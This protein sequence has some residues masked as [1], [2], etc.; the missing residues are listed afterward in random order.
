MEPRLGLLHRY[1]TTRP[2]S[3]SIS[4]KK[5][6]VFGLSLVKFRLAPL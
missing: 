4:A 5:G 6:V 3:P 2:F 1:V